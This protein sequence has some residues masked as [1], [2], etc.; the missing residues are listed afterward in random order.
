MKT[1]L[2]NESGMTLVESLIAIVILLFG[3]LA[4][5]QALAFSVIASKT[6]GRDSGLATAAA[7]DKM[8]EL[9]GLAFNDTTT[10]VTV[11]PPYPTSGT[12]LTAGGSVYP[13]GPAAGYSDYLNASGSRTTSASATAYTRQWQIIN[14]SATSKRIIVTVR[15]NKSFDYGVAPSTTLITRKTP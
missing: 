6:Y 8:E 14:E 15:S 9:I 12:G 2:K 1:D 7:H 4:M 10:N 3:L 11:N 5:A 13:S